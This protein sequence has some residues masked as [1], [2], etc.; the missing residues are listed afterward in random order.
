M[1]NSLTSDEREERAKQNR[2]KR[3]ARIRQAVAR[4]ENRLAV[5]PLGNNDALG[6][7]YYLARLAKTAR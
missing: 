2:A 1:T 5:D 4:V 6:A 7:L 3:L